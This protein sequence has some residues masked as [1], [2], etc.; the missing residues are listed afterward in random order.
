MNDSAASTDAELRA[1]VVAALKRG[2]TVETQVPASDQAAQLVRDQLARL[3]R[4]D[5]ESRLRIAGYRMSPA[6][7]TGH[8][9]LECMYYMR[10]RRWC[11]LPEIDLPA[12]AGWW[13][14]LWR[15]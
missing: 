8:R 12:E 5:I 15:I 3:P 1:R 4:A 10:H 11:A 6:P 7:A 13:C 2:L 9:C 14:R